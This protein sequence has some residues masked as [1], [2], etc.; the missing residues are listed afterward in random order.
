MKTDNLI[1]GMVN[2]GIPHKF[3]RAEIIRKWLDGEIPDCFIEHEVGYVT[4]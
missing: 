1:H 2:T 3:L 4:N